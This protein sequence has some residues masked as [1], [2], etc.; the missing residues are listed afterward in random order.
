MCIVR[1]SLVFASA[2]ASSSHLSLP[3]H[4]HSTNQESLHYPLLMGHQQN[5]AKTLFFLGF[6]A[7]ASV[8]FFSAAAGAAVSGAGAV[9]I[10]RTCQ[11]GDQHVCVRAWYHA[12]T[13]VRKQ[14]CKP[15][16]SHRLVRLPASLACTYLFLFRLGSVGSRRDS[17][18]LRSRR[19]RSSVGCGRRL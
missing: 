17:L 3:L 8:V 11:S 15:Q 13:R 5:M 16:Y 7:G 18:L 12:S 4:L 6:G 19:G 2:C 1:S 9:C 10:C 14:I